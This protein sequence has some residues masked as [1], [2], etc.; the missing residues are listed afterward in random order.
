MT[1]KSRMSFRTQLVL[2]GLLLVIIVALPSLIIEVQRP[3]EELNNQVDRGKIVIS[4]VKSEFNPYQLQGMNEFALKI[5][6][7]VNPEN[8]KYL[9]WTFNLWFDFCQSENCV[10]VLTPDYM[11]GN[12]KAKGIDTKDFDFEKL[13]NAEDFWDHQFASDPHLR[14]I[15]KDYKAKLIEAKKSAKKAGFDFNDTYVM[16]DNGRKLV[17]LLDGSD[18]HESSYPGLE[19]DV[20]KN[21]CPYFRDYLQKGPGFYTNPTRYHLKIFPK[22]DTDKWGSWFSVWLAS[23][24][25]QG[26]WNNFAL[27]FDASR[28]RKLMWTIGSYILT[29]LLLLTL[30]IFL[31]TEK[32]SKLISK[33]IHYLMAGTKA[34]IEANYEYVVPKAGSSEFGE[35]IDNFNRMIIMLKGRVNL[36]QMLEKVLSKELA[37]KVEKDGMIP[38]GQEVEATILMTDFAGYSTITQKLDPSDTTEMLNEY[39]GELVPI[40]HKW[41]GYLDKFIGDAIMGTFGTVT[42][43]ENNAENA[44]CC[45]IEM[46]LTVRKINEQRRKQ[47]KPVFEMRIGLDTGKVITGA[48]GSK[49][50]IDITCIGGTISLAQRFESSC[51]IGHILIGQKTY[52]L[53]RHIFF[54][55]VDIDEAPQMVKVKEY[56]QKIPAYNIQV[57]NLKI[58]KNPQATCNENFYIY[59]KVDHNLKNFDNL[60]PEQKLKFT[61]VVKITPS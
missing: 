47:K 60:P 43:L 46:Q 42:D 29:T 57:A 11:L 49:K 2:F 59:E 48:I 16:T 8:E 45:A 7:E 41:L 38:D 20:Q 32:L 15:F 30:I 31:V 1:A 22:F 55:N 58:S 10:M 13:R 23:K 33:P 44:V 21:N 61:K 3:W 26:N 34:V 56:V 14:I 35:I 37:E 12:L 9:I 52:E 6:K 40:I 4:Q 5:N 28:V 18:W 53:V 39:Y 54:E 50:K 27:D 25:N 24:D 17:F 36:K 51:N 19:Y